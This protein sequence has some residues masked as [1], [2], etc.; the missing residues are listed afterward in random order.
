M[1]ILNI[2]VRR[3]LALE[4]F[5]KAVS[6]HEQI[7]GQKARLKFEYPQFNLKIAQVASM[8]FIAGPAETLKNF[9]ETNATFLVDDI[10]SY[11]KELPILGAQIVSPLKE[12]PTGWN[13]RVLHPDG[14]LVEYVEH[15]DKN[16]AD[17]LPI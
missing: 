7:I 11:E 12:V 8:L 6:F 1:K 2:L 5:E 4:N 16:P 15:R 13:M 3:C 10:K 9:T 17:R 14:T